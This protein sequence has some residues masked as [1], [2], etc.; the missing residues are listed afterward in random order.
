MV[1]YT[2][3]RGISVWVLTG[4]DGNLPTFEDTGGLLTVEEHQNLCNLFRWS[5]PGK[6][7]KWV[8]IST[9]DVNEAESML[10]EIG[11]LQ[12]VHTVFRV[13]IMGRFIAYG[14]WSE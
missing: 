4:E 13:V 9:L 14:G 2:K 5:V 12:S 1:R 11:E 8:L 7:C 3:C 10:G 6:K